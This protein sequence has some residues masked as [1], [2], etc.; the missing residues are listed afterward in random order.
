MEEMWEV[1]ASMPANRV[2]WST[3]MLGVCLYVAWR[4]T[5]KFGPA[6]LLAK[7][8]LNFALTQAM[9]YSATDVRHLAEVCPVG[10]ACQDLSY[11]RQFVT[12]LVTA[13]AQRIDEEIWD[14]VRA[15]YVEHAGDNLC[16]AY[17]MG[18]VVAAHVEYLLDEGPSTLRGCYAD[19]SDCALLITA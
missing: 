8:P 19:I 6:A 17:A 7:R 15:V 2:R 18:M 11:A 5:K 13:A 14:A 1:F 4:H 9:R 10:L 12:H 16:D 3:K